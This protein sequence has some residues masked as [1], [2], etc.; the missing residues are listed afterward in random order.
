MHTGKIGHFFEVWVF[1]AVNVGFGVDGP[2]NTT[3][4]LQNTPGTPAIQFLLGA[5]GSQYALYAAPASHKRLTECP[6]NLAPDNIH[7]RK[8][9]RVPVQAIEARLRLRIQTA[10]SSLLRRQPSE[11]THR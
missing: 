1:P 3:G 4:D 11:R 10:G 8:L 9:W 7:G 6:L 2:H 5:A